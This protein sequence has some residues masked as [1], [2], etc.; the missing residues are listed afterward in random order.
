MNR[1]RVLSLDGGGSWALIEVKAL[2]NL[3]GE[4]TSGHD[5][6]RE[7]DLVAANSGGSIVLGCLVENFTLG[8]ILN[9]CFLDETKRRSIFSK[10]NLIGD[11]VLSDLTGLGPKYSAKNKLPALQRV[12][13]GQG[14]KPLGEAIDGVLGHRGVGDTVRLLIT[15]FDYDRCRATFFRSKTSGG[16][17][18]GTGASA[19][20][21]L[22]EAIHASTNAPVNYFDGPAEF[23]DSPDRYWDGAISGCNNPVLVGVTEAITTTQE[24]EQVIALS[25]G[26][27]SVALPWP[28][29]GQ[30]GSPY[31]QQRSAEGL[32]NDLEKLSTAI[33][34]DPPDMATFLA[35]VMT[36]SG[37]GVNAPGVADSQIVRMNPLISPVWDGA[38]LQWTAPAG[39]TLAQFHALAA[40]GMDA[41]EQHDVETIADYADQWLKDQVPNQPVRMDGDTLH[42]EIGQTTFSAARAAWN[43]IS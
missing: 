27:A 3:F 40:L 22:A 9:K 34:D 31:V 16:P 17:A 7:F 24:F 13:S 14:N 10:T 38:A 11:R 35:H 12:L 6:L 1:Y 39:L 5:V 29:P 19:M 32:V 41:I 15:S 36:G 25:L 42:R 33:L 43:A 20:L 26:S 28:Q 4:Q 23:P 30:E 21:T 37:A 18:Y 8:D 2:I